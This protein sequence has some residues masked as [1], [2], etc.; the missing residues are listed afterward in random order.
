M[1]KKN[2]PC[3]QCLVRATCLNKNKFEVKCVSLYDWF[4]KYYIPAVEKFNKISST[5]FHIRELKYGVLEENNFP[6][7]DGEL[8]VGPRQH[9]ILSLGFIKTPLKTYIQIL[10]KYNYLYI[11]KIN[12][13]NMKK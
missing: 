2:I 10:E 7:S 8:I 6:Y 4:I 1:S 3:K 9:A 5:H 12:L 13:E 11:R